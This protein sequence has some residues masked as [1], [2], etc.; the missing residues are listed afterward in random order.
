MTPTPEQSAILHAARE[1]AANLLINARAGAAKTTTIELIAQALPDTSILC[2]AFNKKIADELRI[3][4]PDNCEAATLNALGHK[5]WKTFT[6]KFPK[7]DAKKCYFLLRE[8]ISGLSA[9]EQEE[10][11]ETFAETL[12]AI[13]TAKTEGYMPGKLHPSARPRIGDESF[14]DLLESEISPLQQTLV[15]QVLRESFKLALKGTIDYDDQIYCTALMPVSFPAYNLVMVDEAQ[16]LSPLNHIMLQKLVRNRRL[17][18]VGDP[19]QAIYA[20]RGASE[21]SMEELRTT[22]DM[23]EH[24]LTI[25]FRSAESVVAN[26]RWRAPDM[27]WRPGAP[28]G[29]VKHLDRWSSEDLDDG[30]AVIC[31]NNAPLFRLAIALLRAGLHPELASGDIIAGLKAIMKKLGKA[32]ATRDEAKAAL[33]TWAAEAE[34]KARAKGKVQDQVDCISI[35]LNETETLGAAIAFLEDV[36]NRAGRIRL[37]TGH[38]SKG[39]EFNRV[40]FLDRFLLKKEGQDLNI[41]YVIETRARETLYYVNSDDFIG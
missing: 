37:M 12:Q 24:Y 17:I 2:L 30:D 20:F 3:R 40:W 15:N 22:F 21:N 16:D 5:A 19:C 6:G 14:F 13:R 23:S 27:Q 26:A 36:A 29:L 35:F 31:R 10:A 28:A 25:C 38:K 39:L 33:S 34:K 8:A 1:T 18:A 7:V 11:W 4:L 9:V 32:G 41:R